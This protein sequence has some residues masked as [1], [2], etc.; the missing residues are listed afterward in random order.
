MPDGQGARGRR[1]GREPA[2]SRDR[3]PLRVLER[4]VPDWFRGQSDTHV[5]RDVDASRR[6]SEQ[7]RRI[8]R[9]TAATSNEAREVRML[10]NTTLIPELMECRVEERCTMK[11]LQNAL[12]SA[13]TLE[14]AT[15]PPYLTA[16]WSIKN[17]TD[18]VAISIREVVQEEMQ[19]MGF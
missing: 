6:P 7:R 12:Q 8:R 5:D 9:R 13:I 15:L 10:T 19:H 16:L 3:Q 2:R 17:E 18:P 11:W 4:R 14:F 1:C